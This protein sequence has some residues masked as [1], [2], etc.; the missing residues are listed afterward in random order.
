VAAQVENEIKLRMEGAEEARRALRALGASLREPRRLE[1]NVLFDATP[2]TLASRG[3]T[4]RVR[5][6]EARSVLTFKGPMGSVDGVKSR[7]EIEVEVSD[8]KRLEAILAGLDL[9]PTFRYQKYRETYS[10]KDAELVV[11]ETPIGV[12]VEIEGPIET[13]HAAASALGRTR[14]DYI[15]ESYVA[16]FFASGGA[17][18][19]VFE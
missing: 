14:D 15:S 6:T 16:L 3:R 12:F 13:I 17:G 7:E 5:R 11:D 8:P 18:D 4:L 9:R 19:M 10:W 1:D 2:S